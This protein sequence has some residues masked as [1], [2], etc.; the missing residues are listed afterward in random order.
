MQWT[1]YIIAE[2]NNSIARGGKKMYIFLVYIHL[3]QDKS[4][5][6]NIL[7]DTIINI[8]ITARRQGYKSVAM[9]PI[10]SGL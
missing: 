3:M 9:P 1:S 8:L 7:M 2:K 10:S 6:L 5:C 4:Q